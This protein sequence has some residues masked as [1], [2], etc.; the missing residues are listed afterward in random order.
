MLMTSVLMTK[1]PSAVDLINMPEIQVNQNMQKLIHN[2]SY[3]LISQA[4]TTSNPTMWSREKTSYTPST[5][6]A[7]PRKSRIRK[8]KQI[9]TKD[10]DKFT[11]LD[12]SQSS[13]SKSAKK[14][15]LATKQRRYKP[16]F[17]KFQKL[18]FLKR[19]NLITQSDSPDMLIATAPNLAHHT[20]PKLK[21]RNSGV[22][23]RVLQ[24]LL[25]ANGY[26]VSIDGNF[27]A[28]TESAVKAFQ[29]QHN[30]KVDGI[31]GSRTWS[32]LTSNSQY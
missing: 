31:V 25:A 19:Q 29:A 30:L 26:Y 22:A 17:T 23:V 9:L 4:N 14:Q 10:L 12:S 1:Q 32:Y 20:L 18:S 21:F 16:V 15:R 7:Q 2:Q 13:N 28:L 27:G 5:P 24:R 6:P 11:T 8:I 3:Q